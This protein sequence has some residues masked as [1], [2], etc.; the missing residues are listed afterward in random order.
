MAKSMDVWDIIEALTDTVPTKR[1]D[2]QER[3]RD[4]EFNWGATRFLKL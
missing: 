1:T 2:R 4:C 3:E